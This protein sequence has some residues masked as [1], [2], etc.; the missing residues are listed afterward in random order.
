MVLG[1]IPDAPLERVVAVGNAAGDGA[2]LA[3]LNLGQRAEAARLAEW[4]EHVQI[5]TDPSFQNEFVAAMGL[6]HATDAFPHLTD[7]LPTSSRP[8]QRPSRRRRL[9]AEL[10]RKE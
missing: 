6:P 7:S 4:V 2:R 8:T 9:G 10:S 5:A 3:L 1:L